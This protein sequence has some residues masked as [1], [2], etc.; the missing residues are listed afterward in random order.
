[1]DNTIAPWGAFLYRVF[2]QELW[3]GTLPPLPKAMSLAWQLDPT[4][5]GLAASQAQNTFKKSHQ[6]WVL[7]P[8]RIQ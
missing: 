4:L 8:N 6:R 3:L 7:L 2:S 5:L 1:V